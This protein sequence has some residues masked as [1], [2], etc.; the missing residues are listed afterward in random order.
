M[1]QI[2]TFKNIIDLMIAKTQKNYNYT[3]K[4]LITTLEIICMYHLKKS[5]MANLVIQFIKHFMDQLKS[6]N[7]SMDTNKV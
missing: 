7:L 4:H 5:D 2:T 3:F 1:E 6:F